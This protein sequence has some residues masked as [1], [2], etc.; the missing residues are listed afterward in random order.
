MKIIHVIFLLL[1]FNTVFRAQTTNVYT[2]PGATTFTVPACVTSITVQV[3]GGGGGGGGVASRVNTGFNTDSE[4]CSAGGGGGGGGYVSRTYTVTPGDVYSLTIGAGGNGGVGNNASSAA[5]NG[6]VGGTSSFS[7]P[8]TVLVG[9]TL[10]A[11]GGGFGGGAMILNNNTGSHLGTNGLFGTGGSGSGGT[12]NYSGGNGATGKHDAS[13]HDQSGGGGGGAGTAGNG[14]NA[15]TLACWGN[16]NGGSSGASFGG[17]GGNGRQGSLCTSSCRDQ[18]AGNSGTTIGAGGGGALIHDHDW[19]NVWVTANGGAG[20]R[21]EIRITYTAASPATPTIASTSPTCIASGSSTVSNYNASYTYNFTPPGPSVGAGGVITGMVIGTNYTLTTNNG[22][23]NSLATSSFSNAAI[24]TTP[25]IPTLSSTAPTCIASGI[26]TVSNY[27]ASLIYNFTPPGPTVGA[28]GIISGM[29]VGTS[30]QV[31]GNNGSCSS[32]SSV[33]FSISA[34]LPSPVLPTITSTSPTCISSGSTTVSNYNAGYTYNFTPPGPSVGAGGVISGMVTGTNYTLTANNGS[35]NSSATSSFS[36]A[37]ILTTPTI[38]MGAN[39]TITCTNTTAIISGSSTTSGVNYAWV[40]PGTI[41][42]SNQAVGNVSTAGT[43]TLTITDP[44]TGCSNNNTI[45]VASNITLPDVSMGSNQTIDCTSSLATITGTSITIGVN[46]SWSGPG[47]I[48]PSNTSSGDVTNAGT[49]TLTITNPANGC[50]ASGTVLVNQN[51]T[52]PNLSIGSNQTINCNT[53][54]VTISG[55][56]LTSGVNYLWTGPSL[57]SPNNQASG[58]VSSAGTYTL[59]VTDPS[60]GCSSSNTVEVFSNTTLPNVSAGSTQTITCT[61]TS[62][63]LSGSST[64]TGVDYSWVGTSIVNPN[65]QANGSV[66]VAG[67]YTLTVIDPMNGCSNTSSVVVTENTTVPNI[68]MSSNQVINCSSS[69]ATIS[70]SSITSGVDYSWSGPGAVNPSNAPSGSVTIAGIYTLTITDP[71]NG[72]SVNGTIDVTN[73]SSAPVITMG[74][75]QTINCNTTSVNID[76]NSSVSGVDYLWSGPGLITPNNSTSGMVSVAGT[77]TLLVTD[78]NNGCSSTG[79]IDVLENSVLPILTMDVDQTLDCISAS[80][81]VSGN[82]TT[83]GVNYSWSGPGAVSPSNA[84]SG[85]VSVAGIYT[86]LVSD[87]TNGCSV[88]GTINVLPNNIPTQPTITASGSTSFC[89][90]DS[91]VLNSSSVLDNVWSNGAT[92]QSIVVNA[93]GTYSVTV[94]GSS[95]CASVSAPVTVVVNSLPTVTAVASA[96]NICSGAT[97][98]LNGSGANTYTWTGGVTDGISFAASSSQ[99]YTVTGLDLNGCSDT[100]V[101]SIN[102]NNLPIVVATINNP[103][104]CEGGSVVLT[105]TGLGAGGNYV[106]SGGVVDNVSF[107]PTSSTTYTVT[108]TDINGCSN[109][110][111]ASVVVNTLPAV[112][113]ITTIGSGTSVCAG[114]SITLSANPSVG[115]TW[116]P[117]GETTSTI[118]VSNSGVYSAFITDVNSCSS[119]IG[120]ISVAINPSPVINVGALSLDTVKCGGVNGGIN[121]VEIIGGTQ[122]YT[123]NWINV[124]TNLSVGNSSSLNNVATGNYQ[125]IVED[126]NGCSDTSVTVLLPSVGGVAVNLTGTPLNGMDP[127]D[128]DLVATSSG[129]VVNYNWF[130]NSVQ[131]TTT[132]VGTHTLNELTFGNYI[133]TVVVEDQY[134]CLDTSQVAIVVESEIKVTIPNVFTP[135]G[136]NINE[137]FTLELKGVKTIEVQIFNRWGQKLYSWNTLNGGWDGKLSNGENASEGT[138]YFIVDYT[139]VQDVKVNRAGYF[140]LAN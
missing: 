78:P 116:Q 136:D 129:S 4:A 121:N 22:S 84:S 58:S 70:G 110:A 64:T 79:T 87:P 139:D 7:G 9:A 126:A 20:A 92:S 31:S 74:V 114:Q 95:G 67:T 8:A 138:Y 65:N 59:V 99:T 62:V 71:S 3:W 49:Y 76:G 133:A 39:Q 131:L 132:Q 17:T 101:V 98:T 112:P 40:G 80:A 47:A 53:A 27:N 91:I 26:S 29:A 134:G 73:N 115:I 85:M 106:W 56:S 42:P 16:Q 30:Y 12:T 38:S 25:S 61:S 137:V 21:G 5:G 41:T 90:G 36:N 37:A 52:A 81:I 24:L 72:C 18:L 75:N 118:I 128:V 86:L 10:I 66:S 69:S 127:L 33:D 97:I 120:S 140:L 124:A 117:N 96:V 1:F 2:T 109:T 135:N 28:G 125:M 68:T 60:N 113:I 82:S 6:S 100:S 107:V 122:P 103:T 13:C 32:S 11:N 43:Y 130:L 93:A 54:T 14:G 102:V 23:C 48:S 15:T 105:A 123:Y 77:Y 104:V 35:C 63:T 19:A 46:Y 44:L 119:A 55:S 111:T 89:D 45:V 57:V 88:L 108:G 50:S 94:T 83:S 51:S 34:I